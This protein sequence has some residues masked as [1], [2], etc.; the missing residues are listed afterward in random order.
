MIKKLLIPFFIFILA[1]VS[2]TSA[3]TQEIDSDIVEIFKEVK[4]TSDF[5]DCCNYY[6]KIQRVKEVDKSE[7]KEYANICCDLKKKK[8]PL[9][10]LQTRSKEMVFYF[11]KGGDVYSFTLE[12]NNDLYYSK[13]TQYTFKNRRIKKQGT[14]VFKS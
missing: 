10:E 13:F 1:F 4:S 11:K 9:Y 14:M 3:Q 8:I 6:F 12:K 2:N 5:I 7:F